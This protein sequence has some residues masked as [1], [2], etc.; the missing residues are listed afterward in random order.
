[1][2]FLTPQ[3]LNTVAY[4]YKVEEITEA[5][6]SIVLQAIETATIEVQGYLRPNNKKEYADGRVVYDV[7]AVFAASGTNRNALILQYT[8]IC[9]LWHLIILCNVDIIYENVKER[10]DR[11][12]DY[13]K[14]VNKGDVTLDLPLLPE[15]PPGTTTPKQPFRFGSRT[16][17]NHE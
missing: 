15:P 17:F 14:M 6:D 1:M 12:I 11:T 13:L 9:A 7:S 3:E 4:S 5:D 8:K 16:K 10:Y 2:A